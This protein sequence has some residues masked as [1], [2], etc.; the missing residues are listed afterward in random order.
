MNNEIFYNHLN[1]LNTLLHSK[2]I[3]IELKNYILAVKNND[4]SGYKSFLKD[5]IA[6]TQLALSD[7]IL[8][9]KD[10]WHLTAL[11]TLSRVTVDFSVISGLDNDEWCKLI[12]YVLL[13]YNR[14]I[15]PGV[16]QT[17]SVTLIENIG[18]LKEYLENPWIPICL[19]I[20]QLGVVDYINKKS[21][22][23][24]AI[25]TKPNK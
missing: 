14:I 15:N 23:L 1:V 9:T 24:N 8:K 18:Y 3:Y 7:G 22:S 6:N 19:M 12:K 13:G 16:S 17:G 5:N 10:G 21:E 2:P 11:D 20:E 25:N 4:G